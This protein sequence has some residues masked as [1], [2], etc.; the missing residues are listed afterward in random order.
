MAL[1]CIGHFAIAQNAVPVK[2]EI[3]RE[4]PG[5]FFSNTAFKLEFWIQEKNKFISLDTTNTKMLLFE[6]D[7]GTNILT[8]HQKAISEYEKQQKENG[9]SSNYIN[10]RN[11]I[12]LE[13]TRVLHD[14]IGFKLLLSSLALPAENAKDLHV[15]AMIT[16]F[17]EDASTPEQS[18]IIKNFTPENETANWQGK[19]ISIFKSGSSSGDEN[20]ERNIGYSLQNSDIGV[21]VKEIVMVDNAGHIIKNLGYSYWEEG[22]LNFEIPEK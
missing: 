19:S 22:K 20:N 9:Y 18:T 14:T 1:Y 8:A 7:L 10:N 6:D 4:I 13:N 5:E 15:Y 16:Y 21:A 12:D 11:I 3:E 17:T 2:L